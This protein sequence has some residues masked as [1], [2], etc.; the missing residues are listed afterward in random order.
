[1]TV[2]ASVKH[3]PAIDT[4]ASVGVG[5][6]GLICP[7]IADPDVAEVVTVEGPLMRKVTK[8][9]LICKKKSC[10]GFPRPK[11]TQLT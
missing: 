3:R 11:S 8:S 5:L 1:M 7:P 2:K 10:N 4:P 6:A 9:S